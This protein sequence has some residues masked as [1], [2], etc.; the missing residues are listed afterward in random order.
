MPQRNPD[1]PRMVPM[2][3]EYALALRGAPR[4]APTNCELALL[5]HAVLSDVN[6]DEAQPLA[7][8]QP[9]CSLLVPNI[10]LTSMAA[11]DFAQ[12][13]LGAPSQGEIIE[14]ICEG[15]AKLREAI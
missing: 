9:V 3:I 13:N 7:V 15:L 14:R 1:F 2:T 5:S 12:V 11:E 8:P 4:P 10:D 6:P